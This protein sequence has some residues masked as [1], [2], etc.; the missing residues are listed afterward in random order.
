MLRILLV[1]VLPWCCYSFSAFD[2]FFSS[3]L[4]TYLIYG[5]IQL[6]Y[7]LHIIPKNSMATPFEIAHVL[8]QNSAEIFGAKSV[9]GSN[10]TRKDVYMTV[11]SAF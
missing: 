5:T 6:Q 7:T 8:T 4:D 2:F 9:N 1:L 10:E 3:C 11:F